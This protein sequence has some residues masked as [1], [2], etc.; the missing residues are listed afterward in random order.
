MKTYRFFLLLT[1]ALSLAACQKDVF[2]VDGGTEDKIKNM[3]LPKAQLRNESGSAYF[4][5]IEAFDDETTVSLHLE[6]SKAS[7]SNISG[8]LAYG[9]ASVITQYN[10]T[11]G[12]SYKTFPAEKVSF[13]DP[14]VVFAG[15][16]VSTDADI[17]ITVDDS[18]LPSENYKDGSGDIVYA[19]P[20]TVTTD[21]SSVTLPGE[22]HIIFVKNRKG[23]TPISKDRKYHIFSCQ[24]T[25][26][27]SPLFH[28]AL[29]LESTGEPLFDYVIVFS[30]ALSWNPDEMAIQ[31]S[32]NVCQA[33]LNANYEKFVKPLHDRG[34][35]VIMSLLSTG[36]NGQG[37]GTGLTMSCIEEDTAKEVAKMLADYCNTYHID[38]IFFDEE[39]GQRRSDIPGVAPS[40]STRLT[41]RLCYETKKAMPDK[42]VIAYNYSNT[43]YLN[44][45]DG[46]YPKDYIDW[47]IADYGSWSTGS[48]EGGMPLS[49][50]TPNSVNCAPGTQRWTATPYTLS[51]LTSQG[52]GGYMVYCLDWA[53]DTWANQW[54]SLQ[55]I[56][57]YL[58]NDNLVDT[59]YRPKAEW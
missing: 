2:E 16:K 44:A 57:Y 24:E 38:G 25:G 58:F 9:D 40:S 3:T 15:K 19:I 1:A 48:Y 32:P 59:G 33:A 39:Y 23:I 21:D 50:M 42:E 29:E 14:A 12:T 53:I 27:A 45:V 35:K 5:T 55:N 43:A 52:W 6:L 26:T 18:I 46:V 4:T 30:S 28:L 8:T 37:P 13:G 56:A 31:V 51:T 47:V 54:S 36:E 22:P 11:Y 20:V 49:K 34:I 7:A 41:S 17:T 10:A